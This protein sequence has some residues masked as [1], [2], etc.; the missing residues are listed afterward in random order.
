MSFANEAILPILQTHDIDLE[1][2]A[3][4]RQLFFDKRL[5]KN[6]EI[7]CASCHH[8]QLNGADKLA[9]SKGVAG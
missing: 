2:S 9:L 6:N 7:S 8:L 3:S 4:G 5:S 1:K